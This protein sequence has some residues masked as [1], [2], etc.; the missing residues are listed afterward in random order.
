MSL[1]CSR[2]WSFNIRRRIQK[3]SRQLAIRSALGADWT[4]GSLYAISRQP[5]PFAGASKSDCNGHSGVCYLIG[6]GRDVLERAIPQTMLGQTRGIH[7]SGTCQ[8]DLRGLALH[9][10]RVDVG[11]HDGGLYEYTTAT[12][13][14][15]QR[16][17]PNTPSPVLVRHR[18][19]SKASVVND[20]PQS[21]HLA[22]WT[23]D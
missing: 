2:I 18:H 8:H 11:D 7:C 22:L 9:A 21:V 17:E 16:R 1:T 3:H 19:R 15:S 4:R 12:D 13:F 23:T 14:G 20:S 10:L 6:Q 5:V